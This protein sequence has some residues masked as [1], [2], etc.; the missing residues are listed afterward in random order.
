[1][2]EGFLENLTAL[3]GRSEVLEKGFEMHPQKKAGTLTNL[4]GCLYLTMSDGFQ[5]EKEG[6]YKSNEIASTK[7]VISPC[8]FCRCW[9]LEKLSAILCLS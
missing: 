7:F 9:Y 3:R 8:I 4:V 5:T 6:F 1:M 2:G